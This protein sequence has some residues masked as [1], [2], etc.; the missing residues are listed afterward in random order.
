M[1]ASIPDDTPISSAL[2]K[3]G[4][5]DKAASSIKPT[6][7]GPKMVKAIPRSLVLG[8]NDAHEETKAT[9]P[10]AER[11]SQYRVLPNSLIKPPAEI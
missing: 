6:K 5:K 8:V 3:R 7:K 11:M 1:D 10:N 2:Q 9:I 4:A